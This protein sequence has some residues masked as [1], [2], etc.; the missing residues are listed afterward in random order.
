M[1]TL[2]SN[3]ETDYLIVKQICID[4]RTKGNNLFDEAHQNQLIMRF[5]GHYNPKVRPLTYDAKLMERV[6]DLLPMETI[7]K[8]SNNIRRK[9]YNPNKMSIALSKVHDAMLLLSTKI[10]G[11]DIY[12]DNTILCFQVW[13]QGM[14][15]IAD[16]LEK[17]PSLYFSLR[18]FRAHG[19]NRN[20][21]RLI[22][23]GYGARPMEVQKTL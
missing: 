7:T 11:F 18:A 20:L 13:S 19:V 14:P 23:E 3:D 16:L 8:Y 15:E 21:R 2:N 10:E 22:E 6:D 4:Q 17:N 9:E 12:R 1:T 5:I